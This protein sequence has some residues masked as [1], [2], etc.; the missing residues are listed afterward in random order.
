MDQLFK[1]G[2]LFFALPLVAFGSQYFIYGAY[3]GGLP[4]VPPWAPG[5]RIGAYLIGAILIVAGACIAANW[6]SRVCATLIAFLFFFFVFVFHS[7]HLHDVI[8]NG[9]DRTRAFE[10]LALGAAALVLAALLPAEPPL[11]DS[12]NSAAAK[13]SLLGRFVF[14]ICSVIFGIQHFLYAPFIASLIPAWMPARLFL[15]Y[16]TGIAF[17]AA[18]LSMTFKILFRLSSLLLALMFFLWV[19]L[20]HSPRVAVKLH[21]GDEW[22]SLFVALAMCGSFLILAQSAASSSQHRATTL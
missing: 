7:Q 8:Y 21:N 1:L 9:N 20:L 15:A 19:V 5:G 16:F 11:G 12:W 17:I 10:P 2:R 4:P 22:A 3:Q 18:G 14:A 6:K 13:L